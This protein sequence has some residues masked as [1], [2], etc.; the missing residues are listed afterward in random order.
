[1]R[2]DGEA[3]AILAN[4]G[5][6]DRAE[7]LAEV[8]RRFFLSSIGD[9]AAF[10]LACIKLDRYEFAGASRLTSSGVTFS[11]PM[12]RTVISSTSPSSKA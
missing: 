11:V 1:M 4:R 3:R 5:E 6:A 12:T 2:A 7:L 8:V 9:D 10:E